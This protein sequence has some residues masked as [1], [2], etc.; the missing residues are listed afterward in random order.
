MASSLAD[1]LAPALHEPLAVLQSLTPREHALMWAPP[2]VAHTLA[3]LALGWV[4]D[5]TGSS[6]VVPVRF[7]YSFYY[8]Y[9][10]FVCVSA[11]RVALF[12]PR[13]YVL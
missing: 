2:A 8:N 3:P 12:G 9:V 5:K 1:H 13:N 11:L 7:S 10:L 6:V 4:Q